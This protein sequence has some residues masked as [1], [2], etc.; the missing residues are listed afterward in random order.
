MPI[1]PANG[2][3]IEDPAGR[4]CS[5]HGVPWFEYCSRC[6]AEWTT[7]R[8]DPTNLSRVVG[9][10]YCARCAAPAPWLS[11]A[12]LI[13]WIRNM[14]KAA[15]DVPETTRHELQD[16]LTRLQAMDPDDT[17]AVAGW[18]RIRD[19]APKVWDATKPIRNALIGEAVK[20]S[21]GL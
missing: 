21:L 13:K 14:I 10:N 3:L 6:G 17:K 20:R 19:V 7:E 1:C 16:V 11:R 5:A 9:D 4:Y 8:Q 2:H 12:D 18:Q 15:P